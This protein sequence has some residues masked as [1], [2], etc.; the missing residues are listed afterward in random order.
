[1]DTIEK[2]SNKIPILKILLFI[3]YK[4]ISFLYLKIKDD[5][6]IESLSILI[7]NLPLNTT[8][9]TSYVNPQFN[10]YSA[11]VYYLKLNNIQNISYVADYNTQF[12]FLN[13]LSDI[14]I[15]NLIKLTSIYQNDGNHIN[16]GI[17]LSSTN[18]KIIKNFINECVKNY[19]KYLLHKQNKNKC[20]KSMESLSI[21]IKN[22]PLETT[23]DTSNDKP[24]FKEYLAIVYYLKHKHIQNI[25]YIADYNAKFIFLNNL[26]NV[27]I[28]KLITFSSTY[29][30][31]ESSINCSISLSSINLKIV[32]EF[33][34]KCIKIYDKYIE[35]EEDYNFCDK[36]VKV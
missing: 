24:Q 19:N 16:C 32:R 7:K 10:E 15:N 36:T 6:T 22:L 23:K 4:I 1:M 31:N 35:N 27:K 8:Y 17:I 34:D 30:N 12:I 21:I 3:L 13:E 9:T 2:I 33:I 11:I 20:V 26:E 14:K 5:K 29:E 28:N 25:S 18:V